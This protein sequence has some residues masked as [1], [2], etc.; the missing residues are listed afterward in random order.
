MNALLPV[1]IAVLLCGSPLPPRSET[2]AQK[3]PA[4]SS[5]V[6]GTVT[7]TSGAP[8]ADATVTAVLY[9]LQRDEVE[10]FTLTSETDTR[11][12]YI[13]SGLPECGVNLSAEA[14][15]HN[16][17]KRKSIQLGRDERV[18][19]IDFKLQPAL[20]ISGRVVDSSGQPIQGAALIAVPEGEK[21]LPKPLV[22]QDVVTAKSG[23]DGHYTIASLSAGNYTVNARVEQYGPGEAA[24]TAAGSQHVDF[25]LPAGGGLS[26]TVR[27]KSSG[28]PVPGAGVSIEAEQGR[29]LE[30]LTE[31]PGVGS[32]KFGSKTDDSGFYKESS[33]D[34]GIYRLNVTAEGY[35]AASRSDV[36]VR[37]GE[38]TTGIDF[39]LTPNP[40][41]RGTVTLEGGEPAGGAVL[42]LNKATGFGQ[43]TIIGGAFNRA[44][45]IADARG[46]YEIIKGKAGE[47]YAVQASFPGYVSALSQSFQL[48]PGKEQQDVNFVLKRGLS[49]SGKVVDEKQNPIPGA[50]VSAREE[51]GGRFVMDFSQNV[52]VRKGNEVALTDDEG[53]FVL[54]GLEAG[55]YEI[56][57]SAKGYSQG[58]V[59]VRNSSDI[60]PE[61]LKIVLK[62]GLAIS[63]RVGDSSGNPLQGVKVRASARG[64]AGY[65]SGSAETDEDG[66]YEI[67]S[68]SP[69]SYKVKARLRGYAEN[70]TGDVSPPAKDIDF[71]LSDAGSIAGRVV[72][73]KT[74][75]PI[76]R[77]RYRANRGHASDHSLFY[78]HGKEQYS[79]DG[80]FETE[81]LNPDEYW[82][83]VKA[84]GYAPSRTEGIEVKSG[85]T[86]RVEVR[87]GPEASITGRVLREKGPAPV[88]GARIALLEEP[89]EGIFN[90]GFGERDLIQEPVLSDDSGAFRIYGLPVGKFKLKA[91]HPDFSEETKPVELAKEGETVRVEFMLKKGRTISGTVRDGATSSPVAGAVVTISS[92]KGTGGILEAMI[93]YVARKGPGSATSDAAGKWEIANIAPGN[94]RL[95][96][97]HKNYAASESKSVT[98]KPDSDVS[99]VELLLSG[100]GRVHGT[101]KDRGGKAISGARVTAVSGNGMAQATTDPD[102]RYALEHLA[103]GDWMVSVSSGK[104][105][106]GNSDVTKPV[107][108]AAGDDSALDFT[109]GGGFS[110]SGR[111]ISQ[112]APLA[113]ARIYFSREEAGEQVSASVES[114][115]DGSY[116]VT[117]L[118]AGSYEVTV[119]KS[120]KGE[121]NFCN[122]PTRLDVS[123]D[124]A[125]QDLV[126]PSGIIAGTVADGEG[127]TLAGVRVRL[128]KKDEGKDGSA[129]F[130]FEKQMRELWASKKSG[131]GGAFEFAMLGAGNYLLTAEKKGIGRAS[132]TAALASDD[133]RAEVA[134]TMRPGFPMKLRAVSAASGKP[135][136]RAA[137]R[138]TD[139][140]G[141]EVKEETVSAEQGVLTVAD[142]AAGTYRVEV[143]AEMYAPGKLDAVKVGPEEKS[144]TELKLEKGATLTVTVA[145]EKNGPVSGAVVELLDSS[146]KRY[147]PPSL[148]KGFMPGGRAVTGSQGKAKFDRL[149]E[150]AFTVKASKA[151]CTPAEANVTLK[152]GEDVKT[153]LIQK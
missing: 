69:G 80:T 46:R 100:G 45:A 7:D 82:L 153:S 38:E 58:E 147:N 52:P 78:F 127:K 63:G 64:E 90:F 151:G 29:L 83:A 114:S 32:R 140:N 12:N 144:A 113:G 35:T 59:H 9:L 5:S 39:S 110:I 50:K 134:L 131:Q 3:L 142:L 2:P 56:K 97:V 150:G 89:E 107:S 44:D 15:G 95:S 37:A 22:N 136:E 124:L 28:K 42:L 71:T 91:S 149:P 8:V 34:T 145:R 6:Q 111:V 33:L 26:G 36:V 47:K 1:V 67:V 24:H 57:A 122:L 87:L 94:Y 148:S 128:V 92:G 54:E 65:V 48:V 76:T 88:F 25:T 4:G 43:P 75:K 108:V 146:G 62:A 143:A 141:D 130:G 73:K 106:S 79:E 102:G 119:S 138:V 109:L 68:L 17:L 13:F 23:E 85:E 121:W 72:E 20:T 137:V 123:G 96:A 11:G 61:P 40:R 103:P 125:G 120:D 27:D 133:G 18:A 105:T 81:Q 31:F 53:A 98:V 86:A 139:K 70:E 93:P 132:V 30:E 117:G 10:T 112:G 115:K 116:R 118:S 49:L 74:G 51:G 14:P 55:I 41:I 129:K 16:R 99:G 152:K 126:L 77:F 60:V 19:G 21:K 135:L 84:E 66:R 104:V 101:V